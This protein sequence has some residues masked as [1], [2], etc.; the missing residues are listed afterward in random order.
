VPA[1]LEFLYSGKLPNDDYVPPHFSLSDL[2]T[3]WNGQC[4]PNDV[5]VPGSSF[6]S[7][8]PND[9]V[10][11]CLGSTS[12][13]QSFL[14]VE[15]A[16]NSRKAKCFSKKLEK[17]RPISANVFEGWLDDAIRDPELKTDG[18]LQG[19]REVGSTIGHIPS[20]T[21]SSTN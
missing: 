2:E 13:M 9:L 12:R 17:P 18:P 19:I 4:I 8:I 20:N 16:L 10:F 1:F 6:I 3:N 7:R 15:K 5:A 11:E 21:S 14:L